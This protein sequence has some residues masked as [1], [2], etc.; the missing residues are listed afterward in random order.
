MKDLGE[1][2]SE[3]DFVD[4]LIDQVVAD[5]D[6]IDD[7]KTLLR[8]KMAA[9]EALNVVSD[10]KTRSVS[11]ATEDDVDDLWDNVPI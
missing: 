2:P 4:R 5:P 11:D 1:Y 7:V 8:H 6:R 9:P 10:A 3:A